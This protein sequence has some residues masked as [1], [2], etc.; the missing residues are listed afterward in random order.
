MRTQQLNWHIITGEYP[1]QIGGVAAY[2]EQFALALAERG[3]P[4]HVWWPNHSEN[5]SGGS[6]ADAVQ[7]HRLDGGF[8]PAGLAAL[9]AGL[10]RFRRPRH[11]LVQYVSNALGMRGCNLFFCLW[12]L[13]RRY[14]YGDDVRVMFHEPYFYFARQS[15]RR[16]VLALITRLMAALLLLASRVAYISIPAWQDLLRPY[17]WW[18][19]PPMVWLPIPATIPHQHDPQTVAALRRACTGGD[20]GKRVVGHFGSYFTLI[21]PAL[22]AVLDELLIRRPDVQVKLLGSGGE[23]F[24]GEFLGSHPEWQGRLSAVGRLSPPEVSLHLQSCDLLIQPYPDG[25]SSRRTSMMAG[26]ANGVASVTTAGSF[27]EPIWWQSG[28]PPLDA[29]GNIAAITAVACELLSD[30]RRRQ[31]AAEQGRLFY[32]QNFDLSRSLTTVLSAPD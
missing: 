5:G 22:A 7:V 16:N 1:P 2:T 23:R 4:V 25:A 32:E 15:L 21:T 9:G 20:P 27:T 14:W 26:L 28:A 18:R 13:V 6:T 19:R 17:C 24:A 12:L 3:W 8:S 10:N 30:N 31:Q 11:L 29:A